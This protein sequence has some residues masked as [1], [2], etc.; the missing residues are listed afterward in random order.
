MEKPKR[1]GI[2]RR[3]LLIE[4][5]VAGTLAAGAGLL[6]RELSKGEREDS[7]RLEQGAAFE[8]ELSF[9]ELNAPE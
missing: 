1:P 9:E 3:E 7:E 6:A 8:K 2:S 4:T 5:A